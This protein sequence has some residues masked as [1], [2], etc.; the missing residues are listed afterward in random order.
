MHLAVYMAMA[1]FF[2]LMNIATYK[3]ENEIWFFFPLIPWGAGLLI[4]YF[5][6]FGIFGI[7]LGRDWE[8]KEVER[9][10]QRIYDALRTQML[11]SPE[12]FDLDSKEGLDLKEYA[13][14]EKKWKEDDFV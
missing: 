3:E 10:K 12:E 8:E 6:V 14:M 4:H 13:E 7:V 5:S 9:E 1:L 11:D 2:L